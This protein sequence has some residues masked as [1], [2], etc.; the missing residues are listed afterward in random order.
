MDGLTLQGRMSERGLTAPIVF[1]SGHGDV[2]SSVRAMKHGA[3]DF[4]EKPFDD[5]DLLGAVDRAIELDAE[6]RKQSKALSQV[7]LGLDRLTPREFEVMTYVITGRMNKVI[8]HEL[9]VSEKTIKIHR[10]RVMKKMEARSLA[11]LVRM[12][13]RAG[14]M[15]AKLRDSRGVV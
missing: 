2:A 14:I 3:V 7:R 8:A 4:I 5:Q 12:T 1:V 10:G 15:A 9:G 13:E 11:D 6:L